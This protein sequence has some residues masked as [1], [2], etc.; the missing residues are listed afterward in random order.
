[1]EGL[2]LSITE[3]KGQF[4]PVVYNDV[5]LSGFAATLPSLHCKAY[6]VPVFR[7]TVRA[8]HIPWALEV[9][10]RSDLGSRYLL[11]MQG[12]HELCTPLL[13]WLGW[14][15]GLLPEL[16]GPARQSHTPGFSPA[17]LPWWLFTC[18][19]TST[20]LEEAPRALPR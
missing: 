5:P 12:F 20:I 10:D 13:G 7:G 9:A 3:V 2:F 18:W 1:M 19:L 8:G 4:E 15:Q 14:S 11:I 17:H 16:S 6:F